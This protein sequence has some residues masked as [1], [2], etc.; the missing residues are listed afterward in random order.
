MEGYLLL[1]LAR[2]D[3]KVVKHLFKG[4]PVDAIGDAEAS[5][6]LFLLGDD[7]Q[8][9]FEDVLNEPVDVYDGCEA[10][11]PEANEKEEDGVAETVT[12]G[13]GTGALRVFND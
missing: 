4:P 11:E 8:V 10:E 6:F 13:F 3:L 9:G 2:F 7:V 12:G 1:V 5:I